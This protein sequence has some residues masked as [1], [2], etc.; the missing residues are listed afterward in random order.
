MFCRLYKWRIEKEI[1]DYGRIK[2]S[3]ILRHIQKCSTC[4]SWSR[5]LI[6]LEEQLKTASENISDSHMQQ[7]QDAVH[8]HL[9]DAAKRHIST[10]TCKIHL[11]R[12]VVSAAALIVIAIGLFS[13]YSIN[14]Y[15]RKK[16]KMEKSVQ[17]YSKQLEQIP[18][19][20]VLPEQ[21]IEDE[22]Q[23][24]QASVRYTIGFVQDCLPLEFINDSHSSKTFD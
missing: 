7:I 13:L 10:K 6:L 14:S 23:N 20:A 24:T 16:I 4:Q 17:Q 22:I 5:S 2:N 11:I 8:N 12:Y 18:A 21:M 19:L 1:D 3:G 15:N 9:S